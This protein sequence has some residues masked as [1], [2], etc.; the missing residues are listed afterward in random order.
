VRK[1]AP[2]DILSRVRISR[3]YKALTGI[4]PRRTGPDTC[5]GPAVW[6][7]GDGQNVSMD[8]DR[9]IWHD[10][11]DDSGGGVLDLIVQVH[12]GSRA[13]ALRWLAAFAGVALDDEPPSVEERA[14]WA[15]ERVDL[16][17]FLPIARYWRRAAV[18][19]T[20]ELLLALKAELWAPSGVATIQPGEIASISHL[21]LSLQSMDG[22]ALVAEYQW[23]ADRYPGMTA[24][25]VRAARAWEQADWRAL[26][27]YLGLTS[28]S[29]G[30][31]S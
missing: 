6:R 3:V 14:R 18:N 23:W 20:Q 15:R 5:R 26:V 8:D 10:F 31:A 1:H 29:S 27:T 22:A 19:L 12:G 7:G 17:R 28:A 4:E 16:E 9:G 21:L 24:A 11:G 2:G 13:D 30:G 25:M